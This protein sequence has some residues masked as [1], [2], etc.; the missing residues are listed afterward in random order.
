MKLRPDVASEDEIGMLASRYH[1][2]NGRESD[3]GGDLV[4]ACK[5]TS[6]TGMPYVIM[7]CTGAA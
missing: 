7:A 3:G 6:C 1:I 4:M 2:L 5:S